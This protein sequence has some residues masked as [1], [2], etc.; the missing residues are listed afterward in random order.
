MGGVYLLGHRALS[1]TDCTFALFV[2]TSA[3]IRRAPGQ[4]LCHLP[5]LVT[6]CQTLTWISLALMAATLCLTPAWVYKGGKRVGHFLRLNN[7]ALLAQGQLSLW[8]LY[9]LCL[10]KLYGYSPNTVT[11]RFSC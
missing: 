4:R 7:Q 6:Q 9:C 10:N 1:Q 2:A 8:C 5:A 3:I 11:R